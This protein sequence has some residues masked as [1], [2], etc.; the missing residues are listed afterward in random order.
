LCC[1]CPEGACLR[2]C[3][4]P[5][6]PSSLDFPRRARCIGADKTAFRARGR[7][8]MPIAAIPVPT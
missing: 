5:F 3:P 1:T 8:C 7:S 6:V 4:A 2:A